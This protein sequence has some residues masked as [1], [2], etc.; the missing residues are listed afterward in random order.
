MFHMPLFFYL[1]GIFHKPGAYDEQISKKFK[2]LIIPLLIFLVVLSPLSLLGVESVFRITTPHLGGIFGPLWFLF[3]LFLLAVIYHPLL[4][5]GP[6]VRLLL[7]VIISFILGYIPS[8]FR[9]ENYAYCYTTFSALMFYACGNIIGDRILVKNNRFYHALTFVIFSF[10][11]IGMYGICYKYLHYGVT[12]L[13]DN[14]LPPDFMLFALSAVGGIGMVLSLSLL[15]NGNNV[16]AKVFAFIG[17][18][19]MYI[20]ALHMPIFMLVRKFSP[21]HSVYIEILLIIF[22]LV[23]G[24][25][26]RPVFKKLAPA[27]FK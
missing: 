14:I 20:F 15:M 22:S 24:C 27:I 16:P 8:V 1:S 19:S 9:L 10:V 4:K 5:F 6:V 7:C 2:G 25:C 23:F 17:E 26:A 18:C 11:L 3:S 13:Y 12:D 21:Y